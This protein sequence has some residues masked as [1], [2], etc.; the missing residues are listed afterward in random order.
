MLLRK[1]GIPKEKRMWKDIKPFS[2]EQ[3][4]LCDIPISAEKL[5]LYKRIID[6]MS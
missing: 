1:L 6:S 3:D 4:S 5:T 2:W